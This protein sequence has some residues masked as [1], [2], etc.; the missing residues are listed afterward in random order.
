MRE[1]CSARLSGVRGYS[2]LTMGNE[3]VVQYLITETEKSNKIRAFQT[4]RKSVLAN[5]FDRDAVQSLL[6]LAIAINSKSIKYE[7]MEGIG[8]GILEKIFRDY[9]P[10]N[11]VKA[12][13]DTILIIHE[14]TMNM[15]KSIDVVE[16]YAKSEVKSMARVYADFM[17]VSE[18][19]EIGGTLLCQYM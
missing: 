3:D 11:S 16:R 17:E 19:K 12:F 15:S 1:N 2:Q 6:Q 5:D 14:D 10:K 4:V 18:K 13:L 9:V 7:D 8:R